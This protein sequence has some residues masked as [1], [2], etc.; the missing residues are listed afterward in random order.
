MMVFMITVSTAFAVCL[1]LGVD[2]GSRALLLP[3]SELMPHSPILQVVSEFELTLSTISQM[4]PS[5]FSPTLR[6]PH[7]GLIPLIAKNLSMNQITGETGP[8]PVRR[9]QDS[10]TDEKQERETFPGQ[11]VETCPYQSHCVEERNAGAACGVMELEWNNLADAPTP[12]ESSWD[13]VLAADVL[14]GASAH[15]PVMYPRLSSFLTNF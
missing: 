15:E 10:K 11:C 14:Y 12:A 6:L 9:G 2:A 8:P 1:S 5:Q 3:N 13:L 7:T 4:S